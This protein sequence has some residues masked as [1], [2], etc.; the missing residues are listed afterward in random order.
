MNLKDLNI[1]QNCIQHLISILEALL[2]LRK[3]KY[4][5]LL[6]IILM[7]WFALV[8]TFPAFAGECLPAPGTC[9]LSNYPL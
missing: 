4:K 6:I 1:K 3:S 9:T 8:H 2:W 7:A 5:C